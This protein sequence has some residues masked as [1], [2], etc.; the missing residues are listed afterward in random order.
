MPN[1]SDD[2]VVLS[3][4]GLPADAG[5]RTVDA[6][7]WVGPRRFVDQIIERLRQDS[8]LEAFFGRPAYAF[9]P[10]KPII[11]ETGEE[12]DG[13]PELVGPIP[14][15]LVL[16]WDGFRRNARRQTRQSLKER[17]RHPPGPQ[18]PPYERWLYRA[19]ELAED[20]ED[21]LRAAADAAGKPKRARGRPKGSGDT[22]PKSD[23]RI[24]KAWNSGKYGRYADCANALGLKPNDTPFTADDVRRAVDRNRKRC[25]K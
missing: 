22:N 9:S 13:L 11:L 1:L 18:A 5:T 7:V 20:L 6:H 4:H 10:E 25:R 23:E 19:T 16:D 24:C 12:I 3:V 17:L 8:F 2:S 14:E 21:Q 15:L